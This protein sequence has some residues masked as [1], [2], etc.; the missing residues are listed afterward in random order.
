MDGA[1]EAE[2][3]HLVA[4]QLGVSV[5]ELAPEVSLPDD[6]AADSLDLVELGLALEA[7]LGV[8]I[9]AQRLESLR[10]YGDLIE[11]VARAQPA[12][13]GA[14]AVRFRIIVGAG[15]R[16]ERSGP[17]D[18]YTIEILVDEARRAGPDARVELETDRDDATVTVARRRLAARGVAV[19]IRRRPSSPRPEPLPP[20][21]SA[22]ENPR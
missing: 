2:I 11:A 10:T 20:P 6:L 15:T 1:Y 18:P 7:R 14:G 19:S 13:E 9:P 16:A 12:P 17:L 3:R 8:T 4:D 22:R 5:E 21:R